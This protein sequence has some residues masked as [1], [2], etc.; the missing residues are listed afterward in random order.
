ME[1]SGVDLSLSLWLGFG[2]STG[3]IRSAGYGGLL[4]YSLILSTRVLSCCG[5]FGDAFASSN[6]EYMCLYVARVLN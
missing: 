4:P 6:T 1:W 2:G 5:R 3:V